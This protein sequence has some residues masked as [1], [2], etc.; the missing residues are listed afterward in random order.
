MSVAF[1]AFFGVSLSHNDNNS[2][3]L[4]IGQ[5]AVAF[6]FFKDED[7]E[8]CTAQIAVFQNTGPRLVDFPGLEANCSWAWDESCD[9]FNCVPYIGPMIL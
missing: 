2:L 3:S 8:S 1:V 7:F 9:S 4:Q 5:E 6:D